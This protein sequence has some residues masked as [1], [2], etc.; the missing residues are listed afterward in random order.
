MKL[1]FF[2][3][4]SFE[5][6]FFG[7]FLLKPFLLERFNFFEAFV[8]NSLSFWGILMKNLFSFKLFFLNPFF[9]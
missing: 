5:A 3:G 9:F 4:V 7:G 8:L 6:F 2:W 1:L